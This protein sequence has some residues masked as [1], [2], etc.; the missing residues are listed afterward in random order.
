MG[1][2][3]VSMPFLAGGLLQLAKADLLFCHN[4]FYALFSGAVYCNLR[5]RLHLRLQYQVSMP[6]LAGGLLQQTL[7]LFLIL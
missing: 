4:S 3:K 5:M 1:R 2:K 6:F 7:F